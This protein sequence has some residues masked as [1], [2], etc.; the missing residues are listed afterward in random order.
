MFCEPFDPLSGP[1]G[2]EV[3]GSDP[4]NQTPGHKAGPGV[5]MEDPMETS[6]STVSTTLVTVGVQAPT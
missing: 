5:D 3:V 2:W 4:Q 1:E 6:Q